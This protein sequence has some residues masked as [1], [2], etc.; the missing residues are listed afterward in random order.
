MSTIAIPIFPLHTVLFPGGTLPLRIFEPRYL[1]MVSQCMK[2]G[3]GF[4]VAL[5]REGSEVGAA[6]DTFDTGTL[7]EI[8]YFN[9]QPDG[10]LGITARGQQRFRIVSRQV[11]PNQLTMADVEL[12]ENEPSSPLPPQYRSA[13]DVLRSLLEQLDQPFI[14]MQKHYDDA[15]WVSS[16]LAELLPIRLEQKQYFLQLDDPIQRLERLAVLLEDLEIR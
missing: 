1:D 10:L 2:A 3:H 9:Q 11:Q 6:A 15:S 12:L 16:R 7:S 13:A 14:N 8:V 4:G 5:I